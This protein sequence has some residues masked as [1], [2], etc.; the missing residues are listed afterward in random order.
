M[1][2]SSP[3]SDA[4]PSYFYL[5]IGSKTLKYYRKSDLWYFVRLQYGLIGILQ[6]PEKIFP[7]FWARKMKKGQNDYE[8]TIEAG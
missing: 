7:I 8:I 1:L 5:L 4:Q 6:A 2:F 3:F